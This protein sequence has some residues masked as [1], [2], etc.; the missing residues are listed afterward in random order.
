MKYYRNI[1]PGMFLKQ[2]KN[3]IDNFTMQYKDLKIEDFYKKLKMN[4]DK[5]VELFKQSFENPAKFFESFL[6]KNL[7]SF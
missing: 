6:E 1:D 4:S 2:F 5:L 7:G 3:T